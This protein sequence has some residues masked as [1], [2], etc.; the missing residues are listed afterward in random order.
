MKVSRSAL[1]K[2]AMAAGAV[3]LLATAAV[4]A[5]PSRESCRSQEPRE[6]TWSWSRTTIESDLNRTW[7]RLM[8]REVHDP[9]PACGMG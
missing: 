4:Q 6:P 9:C 2:M 1:S 3:S 8:G 7:D 5:K